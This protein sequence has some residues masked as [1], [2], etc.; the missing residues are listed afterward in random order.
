LKVETERESQFDTAVAMATDN[1]G[2]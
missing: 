1:G 2:Y